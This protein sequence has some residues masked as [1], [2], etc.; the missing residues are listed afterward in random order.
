MKPYEY[1]LTTGQIKADDKGM[2][3]LA[4]NGERPATGKET[5]SL[6]EQACRRKELIISA[7][8]GGDLDSALWKLV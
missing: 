3:L 5:P 1:A 8:C 6:E 4:V 2:T 7:L